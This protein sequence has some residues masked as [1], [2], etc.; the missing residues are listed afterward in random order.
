[1]SKLPIFDIG[2]NQR[3]AFLAAFG[4]SALA[5]L[6]AELLIEKRDL[7]PFAAV[8]VTAGVLFLLYREVRPT[9]LRLDVPEDFL[10]GRFLLQVV[11]LALLAFTLLLFRSRPGP[12]LAFAVLLLFVERGLESGHLYPTFPNRAFYP[13]L[14]LLD[15]IPRAA[16]YRFTSVGFTFVPNIAALYE[17]EDVRGYEAMTFQP[18]VETFPLWCV[19]QPIW[20]NRVDDPTKPFLA[21]LNVR[22]VLAPEAWAAPSGWKELSH[23]DGMKLYDNPTALERVFVPKQLLHRKSEADQ[24]DAVLSLADFARDGVVGGEGSGDWI[25]NGRAE[26]RMHSYRPER[27]AVSVDAAEPAVVGSS[28]PRWPG[29]KVSIVGRAG[30]VLA[31]NG[32]LVGFYVPSCHH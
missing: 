29:W 15:P 18:L 25:A 7:L 17:L 16:P 2:L 30:E 8:V 4:M 6:G 27:V 10:R 31:Y 5:A 28:I 3:M 9:L 26:V 19:P 21:F 13:P 23:G 11:P 32:F 22:W 12:V 1:V 24:R 20:F 14:T